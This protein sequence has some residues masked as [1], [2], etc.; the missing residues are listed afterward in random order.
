M[1]ETRFVVATHDVAYVFARMD[2]FKATR[3]AMVYREALRGTGV[4][5]HCRIHQLLVN[6]CLS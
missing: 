4:R 1:H 3:S 5:F 6:V 2:A